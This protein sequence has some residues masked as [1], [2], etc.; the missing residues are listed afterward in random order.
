MVVIGRISKP[1][2][3]IEEIIVLFRCLDDKRSILNGS[4][5]KSIFHETKAIV[6]QIISRQFW[7]RRKLN[8][9]VL[10]R[11]LFIHIQFLRYLYIYTRKENSK[12]SKLNRFVRCSLACFCSVCLIQS[13]N[14]RTRKCDPF[15]TFTGLR[16]H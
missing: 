6:N 14:I 2:K 16:V 4:I 1:E 9:A 15:T 10:D 8:R 5:F 3:K 12:H 13:L 11:S 7:P